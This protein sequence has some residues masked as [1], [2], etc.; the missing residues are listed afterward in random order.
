MFTL[1]LFSYQTKRFFVCLN[2]NFLTRFVMIDWTTV[3]FLFF[4]D[5]FLS[6]FRRYFWNSFRGKISRTS[7]EITSYFLSAVEN[8]LASL[9]KHPL[10]SCSQ[11]SKKSRK[12]QLDYF[13]ESQFLK[14]FAWIIFREKGNNSRNCE[15]LSDLSNS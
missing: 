10:N 6:F 9:R 13:R 5:N 14:S 8:W 2:F 12:T 3:F 1:T 4:F 7:L 15:N 11:V